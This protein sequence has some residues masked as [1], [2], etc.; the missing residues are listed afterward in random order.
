[1]GFGCTVPAVMGARTMENE[2]DRRMTIMLVP[3]MS[4]SARLPVYGLITAAF[5]PGKAG[6]VVFSLYVLG[7]LC[8]ILSGVILKKTLFHGEPAPFLL[9]L[10]PYRLPTLKNIT[11]HVWEKVKGFLVKAGTLILAMSVVLWFLQSFGPDLRMVDNAADSLLGL[12]G[13]AIAPIFKPLGFGTWQAAVA[14]LTGLIAKEMV[15]SSMSLFYGFSL[16][17]SGAVV[18]GALSGTFADPAAAYAFLA[19]VLLYVPCVA[20]MATLYREMNSLKWTLISVGWQLVWA[21]GVSFL[22]YHVLSLFL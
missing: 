4:C 10:P 21:W 6:L 20:A 18:A 2:K 16:S 11:L 8:A 7:L 14:L 17:A 1:M 5:F 9:E 15:V 12:I 19:F 13:T 22:V 3:F